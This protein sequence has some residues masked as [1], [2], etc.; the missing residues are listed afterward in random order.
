MKQID[1][2]SHPKKTIA[3]LD[4]LYPPDRLL[5]LEDVLSSKKNF[6]FIFQDLIDMM[7]YGFEKDAVRKRRIGRVKHLMMVSSSTASQNFMSHVS[8]SNPAHSNTK[9]KSQST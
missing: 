7:K 8:T 2:T 3:E 6:N 1:F 4:V 5:I 9:T